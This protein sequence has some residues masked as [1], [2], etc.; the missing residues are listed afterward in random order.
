M[1]RDTA[2]S[3]QVITFL[4][5]GVVFL[6]AVGAA[7]VMSRG[8]GQA[9]HG[10]HEA[11]QQQEAA[12]LADLLVGSAGLGWSAGPD[13]VGRLGLRATNGSGLQQ[14]SLEALRGAMFASASNGK[15]DYADARAS[16]G[17]TG[18]QDFHLRVYPVALGSVYKA[19]DS[20]QRTAYI[21]DWVSLP[22]VTVPL[23]PASAELSGTQAAL[24]ATMFAQTAAER[25]ALRDLGLRFTDSVFLLPASPVTIVDRPLPLLDIPLLTQLNVPYVAGDVYPDINGYIDA[26]LPSRLAYY[27]LLIVGSGV[28]QNAMTSGAVKSAI[29]DWVVAGGTLVVLG[30]DKLNYQWLQPLFG[31]GVKTA[32]GAASAPDPS[33]PLLQEPHVLDWTH[34]DDHGVTWAIRAQD[35]EGFSDVIVKGGND[36]LAISND[37][38]FGNGRI[39][40]TT[41]LP[42][43]IAATIGQKEAEDFLENIVLFTDHSK[44]YLEYGPQQPTNAPVAVEVRQSYLYDNTLGQVP[45][46]IE[47]HYWGS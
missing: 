31:S 6:G 35:A 7:L 29:H 24:N 16:L 44:L 22:P 36:V 34:Y 4:V 41:Y 45:V 14:E 3:G 5:A 20:A 21:G 17:L 27:D 9:D 39:L 11:G 23:G 10:A 1:L 30:S 26:T 18:T 19:A 12:G 8:A 46:R 25:L 15:V 37:G 47:V 33:H 32:N 38:S 40:L 42:R 2:G 43:E 28:D 13:Q